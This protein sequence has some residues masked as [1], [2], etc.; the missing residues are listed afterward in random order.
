MSCECSHV[1]SLE[2][3]VESHETEVPFPHL[4]K[5]RISEYKE[6]VKSNGV[7]VCLVFSPMLSFT[8]CIGVALHFKSC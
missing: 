8:M 1:G 6:F 4:P 5:F 2:T 3:D 7:D